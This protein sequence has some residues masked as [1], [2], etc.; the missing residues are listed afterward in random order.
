MENHFNSGR[1]A[2]PRYTSTILTQQITPRVRC[3]VPNVENRPLAIARR[4]ILARHCSIGTIHRAYSDRIK[5]SR[6]ISQKPRPSTLLP[7]H[8]KLRLVV[9][10]G[11]KP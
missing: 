6:V 1:I 8:G 10:R 9:S 5:K 4:M 3:L 2:N 7:N 11:L